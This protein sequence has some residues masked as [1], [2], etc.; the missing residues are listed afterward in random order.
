MHVERSAVLH[1]PIPPQ[2]ALPLFTPEGEREWVAGW[3][4]EPLHAPGGS[5]SNEGAVFRTAVGGEETLWLVLEVDSA[6]GRAAYVR[7]TPGSRLGTVH[8]RCVPADGGTDVTVRYRLTALSPSGESVIEALTAE[9][10]ATTIEGW[11]RDLERLLA[12]G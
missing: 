4:P 5:L 8:V 3:E 2:E 1:L 10:F 6:A 9:A 7:I 11:R 12:A